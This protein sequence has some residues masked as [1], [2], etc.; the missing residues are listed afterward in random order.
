MKQR[1]LVRAWIYTYQ[2][3]ISSNIRRKREGMVNTSNDHTG[4][5]LHPILHLKTDSRKWKTVAMRKKV[6]TMKLL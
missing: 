5:G 4:E 2:H 1:T 3:N 6:T